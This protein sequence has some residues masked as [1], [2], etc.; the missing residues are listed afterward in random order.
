MEEER[1]GWDDLGDKAKSA[2]SAPTLQPA[3]LS[4]APS[5]QSKSNCTFF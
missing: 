4:L 2:D 5:F 1:E 3:F